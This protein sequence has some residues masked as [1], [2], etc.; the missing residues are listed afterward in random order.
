MGN[1]GPSGLNCFGDLLPR[2]NG[3][4]YY[5]TALRASKHGF[6]RRHLNS[7]TQPPLPGSITDSQSVLAWIGRAHESPVRRIN[8]TTR[9]SLYSSEP[10]TQ[11][12]DWM[13]IMSRAP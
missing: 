6:Y 12:N 4:G 13:S 3:R 9:H 1:V 11:R 2:P 5:M 10:C 8:L 7:T